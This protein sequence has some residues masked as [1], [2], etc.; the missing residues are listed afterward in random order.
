MPSHWSTTAGGHVVQRW[1]PDSEQPR[2]RDVVQQ[3]R[4]HFEN[5]GN[6][7]RRFGG[8]FLQSPKQSRTRRNGRQIDGKRVAVVAHATAGFH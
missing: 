3:R 8:I 7:H 2:L 6:F 5:R 4:L 1:D